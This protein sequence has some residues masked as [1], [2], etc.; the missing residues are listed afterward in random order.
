M[1]RGPTWRCSGR[2]PF[3]A[4]LGRAFSAERQD[5]GQMMLPLVPPAL[6]MGG[7]IIRRQTTFWDVVPTK[8]DG[9]FRV[10]FIGKVEAHCDAEHYARTD[11]LED[12]PLLVDH[13]EPETPLFISS[14]AADPDRT[15]SRL[16]DVTRSF[17]HG[18]RPLVRYLNPDYPSRTLLAEGHG[19]LLR[20]PASY[21]AACSEIVAAEGVRV[22]PVVPLTV[23]TRPLAALCFDRS[24]VVAAGFR[25][26]ALGDRVGSA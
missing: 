15:L 23:D 1:I 2:S 4:S 8:H 25:F 19:L 5:V 11:L 21:V 9:R 18:W 10:H 6:M 22:D 16:D 26:D 20:G 17:F 24:Y 13:R 12:H 3:L 7:R 14:R